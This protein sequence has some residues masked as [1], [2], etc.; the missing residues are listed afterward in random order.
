[1][2]SD[3]PEPQIHVRLIDG[4]ISEL[5]SAIWMTDVITAGSAGAVF[6]FAG[7]VRSREVT[8]NNRTQSILGLE[9]EVY[10]PMTSQELTRLSRLHAIKHG[11][12]AVDVQHSFGFIAN[13]ECSFFLQVAT[14]HREEAIRFIDEFIRDMKKHVPIWKVPRLTEK[15]SGTV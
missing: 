10:E 12:L 6:T 8:E 13:G 7:H 4:P 9:Y 3:A 11:V 15:V 2:P 1:M 14:V 5:R